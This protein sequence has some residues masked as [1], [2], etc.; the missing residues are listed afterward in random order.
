MTV[1]H[2][3]PCF[4]KSLLDLADDSKLEVGVVGVMDVAYDEMAMGKRKRVAH[5]LQGK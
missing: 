1:V 2:S 4:E 5:E 3:F